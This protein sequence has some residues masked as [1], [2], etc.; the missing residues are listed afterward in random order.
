MQMD[1]TKDE[2]VSAI[3]QAL[4]EAGWHDVEVYIVATTHPFMPPMSMD[5]EGTNPRR[6][7][8]GVAATGHTPGELVVK[9]RRH[10]GL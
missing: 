2:A 10:L 6:V 3:R 4:V 5:V 8:E 1:M 9:I 7:H